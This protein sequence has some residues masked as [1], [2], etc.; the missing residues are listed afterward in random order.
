MSS[1][2]AIQLANEHR[3]NL[4]NLSSLAQKAVVDFVRDASTLTPEQTDFALK[5]ALPE[6]IRPYTQIS[7]DL[8]TVYYSNLRNL[9]QSE[10]DE[11]Y[12]SYDAIAP[13][14]LPV[15]AGRSY[16]QINTGALL[17]REGLL[18]IGGSL[19][20]FGMAAQKAV[21]SGSRETIEDLGSKDE[22]FVRLRRIP[23]AG[24]CAWCQFMT[25]E[26]EA[27][28]KFHDGCR[29]VYGGIF[30]GEKGTKYNQKFLEK[31]DSDYEK[32]QTMIS[33]RDDGA[34]T[35]SLKL[36]TDA[37]RI[38]LDKKLSLGARN[39]R[40]DFEKTAG[41]N[42]KQSAVQRS[43]TN[44][45]VDMIVNKV[46]NK[47]ELTKFDVETLTEWG[48]DADSI[49]STNPNKRETIKKSLSPSDPDDILSVMRRTMGY[50]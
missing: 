29:C 16:A 22:D 26:T 38:E 25:V 23:R 24:A 36:G 41:L 35:K 44:K 33:N 10:V 9:A 4:N 40:K 31:F 12:V 5:N 7:A 46:N 49:G 30:M 6:V 32:A 45:R 39:W 42:Q 15:T 47:E 11:R 27:V 14:S 37:Y 13:V 21:N 17:L 3:T 19:I 20:F 34:Q 43:I 48:F 28:T 1:Q 2:K 18:D 50:H 8:T